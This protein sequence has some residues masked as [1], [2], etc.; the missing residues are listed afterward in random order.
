[1]AITC[2]VYLISR[3]DSFK[4]FFFFFC[5]CCFKLRD[6][7]MIWASL[8]AET[9]KHM[10]AMQKTLGLILGSGRFPGEGKGYPL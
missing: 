4:R 5:H 2:L 3:E 8:V 6:S 9:V 7:I 1:M 10:P